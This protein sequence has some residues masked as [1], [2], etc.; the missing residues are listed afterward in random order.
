M[1]AMVTTCPHCQT[2]FK[3]SSEQL[4]AHEGDVRCGQCTTVFNAYDSLASS[5]VKRSANPPAPE[6][7]PAP[8]PLP[9][10]PS[11]A[12]HD[13]EAPALTDFPDY[14]FES[15]EQ[16]TYSGVPEPGLET[17]I[18][19]GDE[20]FTQSL[21]STE[22]MA[23]LTAKRPPVT[24]TPVA[25][26]DFD[27]DDEE[28]APIKKRAWPWTFG[29]VLLLL[30]LICQPVFFRYQLAYFAGDNFNNNGFG[31]HGAF[32]QA[33][34]ELGAELVVLCNQTP[35]PGRHDLLN[36]SDSVS[37]ESSE[38][39]ADPARPT[40]VILN[41]VLRNHAKFPQNYPGLELTLTD[42]EDKP[43]ARRTFKPAVSI[44]FR[45]APLDV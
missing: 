27:L 28:P 5:D 6:I 3:V 42:A 22:D 32:S 12:A 20:P 26:D 40:V 41:A 35:C 24:I 38:L 23:I 15:L 37:I 34:T 36:Y 44:S 13:N 25:D 9:E 14:E 10:L 7:T 21:I 33:L 17:E 39:Q 4:N 43:T 11:E 31:I 29:V 2:T 8:E 45:E 19:P 18:H 30:T 1:G 16:I